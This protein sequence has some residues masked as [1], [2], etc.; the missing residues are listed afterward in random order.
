ILYDVGHE[1]GRDFLV[2]EY[3]E[4]ET[5][6]DRLTQGAIPIAETLKI[7][8]Q[9]ADALDNAHRQ[10]LVHRDLKPGNVQV[11]EGHAWV[12]DFGL[13][14]GQVDL[15]LTTEGQVPGTLAYM[16]PEQ[17]DG[18]AS[19]PDPS[20]DVYSLGA[21]IYYCIAGRPPFADDSPQL[22]VR[23][24]LLHEPA[25]LPLHGA[26]RD[27]A[28]LV[29]R[30]LEKDPARRFRSALAMA[31]ELERFAAGQPIATRPPSTLTRM[32]KLARRHRVVTAVLA[33]ALLVSLVFGVRLVAD[34]ARVEAE[35]VRTFEQVRQMVA[36]GEVA[37]ALA[38]VDELAGSAVYGADPR[39]AEV[40]HLARSAMVLE[41]VLD[42]IQLDA[43]S[44]YQRTVGGQELAEQLERAHPDVLASAEVTVAR[45][46]AAFFASERQVLATRIAALEAAGGYPRLAAALRA[47]AAGAE[48]PH[49]LPDVVTTAA[50]H[51][52]TAALLVAVDA[53]RAAVLAEIERAD[54]RAP[55]DRRVRLMRAVH[56]QLDGEIELAIEGGE[57]LWSPG[58]PRPE[59]HCF[60]GRQHATL[61]D[62][63]AA[64]R[65]YR[66]AAA[67]L[68][69]LDRGPLLRLDV[70]RLDLMIARGEL[71][72]ARERLHT[73]RRSH[74]DDVLL[75]L[76]EARLALAQG[77]PEAARPLLAR[78][79][80]VVRGG[81]AQRIAAA[82]LLHLDV[83]AFCRQPTD[84][85]VSVRAAEP[86][87]S[88]AAQLAAEAAAAGEKVSAAEAHMRRFEVYDHLAIGASGRAAERWHERA[89]DSLRQAWLA[90]ELHPEAT[91]QVALRVVN[92]IRERQQRL[93]ARDGA[94][95]LREDLKLGD[96]AQQAR[97]RAVAL[98]VD[99][100][101]RGGRSARAIE[102]ALTASYL[103]AVV[104]DRA[105]AT[106]CG[107]IG[108]LWLE[109]AGQG[110]ATAL[111]RTLHE[112][113]L[114]ELGITAWP[115][116]ERG[117]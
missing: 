15:T 78:F 110:E 89:W 72:A 68:A 95:A 38:R 111:Q 81:Q 64:S 4:G 86:L 115:P 70:S 44:V 41:Q 60:L 25:A 29:L 74:G 36:S 11:H 9:I 61:G 3:L 76:S 19:A 59:L 24:A 18:S 55:T 94:E 42:R 62:H 101:A 56:R 58:D 31:E 2:M 107:A 63:A 48:P 88:R 20:G 75:D 39:L 22:L 114:A 106:R 35:R 33:T 80:Q 37:P 85:V 112:M 90:Q 8:I 34:R 43:A 105:V 103:S 73:A 51:V 30:A 98:T 79:V 46:F 77:D 113:A 87:L 27:L 93:R 49:E 67:A 117:G 14:R 100:F 104:G 69:R 13:A 26:D 1:D 91:C 23:A 45:C 116:V 53:P 7:A 5:L 6:A 65:H 40:R 84:G 12:L 28:T 83:H 50:D 32:V 102:L 16:P 17:L 57:M 82:A 47:H 54:E 21:T 108:G 10:G 66:L 99:A 96:I 92:L 52:F 109:E 97:R 71:D